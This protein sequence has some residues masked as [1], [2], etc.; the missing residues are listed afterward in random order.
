MRNRAAQAAFRERRTEY[1]KHLEA[2]IKQHEETLSS[3]QQSS[4][5]A[6]DEVL[7]LRYKNSLLERILLEKGIN[8]TAELRAFAQ[9]NDRPSVPQPAM[10]QALPATQPQHIVSQQSPLPQQHMQRAAV[11]G[12]QDAPPAAAAAAAAAPSHQPKREIMNPQGE[13]V[14]IKESPD[15]RVAPN[16]RSSSVAAAIPTPPDQSAFQFSHNTTAP[17]SP[18]DF[19]PGMPMAQTYYPS[20]YQAHMEELGKELGKLP[21]VLPI[22][23]CFVLKELGRPRLIP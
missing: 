9:Y 19:H 23:L 21:R 7:M 14:Y 10:A 13:S 4:R 12:R 5:N 6:A 11:V 18:A 3:L 15:S 8:V 22:L 20:P 1:I 17:T 2:T 16:S